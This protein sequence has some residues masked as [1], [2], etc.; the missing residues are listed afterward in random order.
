M[1]SSHRIQVFGGGGTL[2]PFRMVRLGAVEGGQHGMSS[3]LASSIIIILTNQL[4]MS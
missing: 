2:R 3:D 1:F 4:Q